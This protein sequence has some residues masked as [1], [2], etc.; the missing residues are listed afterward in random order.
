MANKCTSLVSENVCSL[1]PT[2]NVA[3]PQACDNKDITIMTSN[4]LPHTAATSL[5]HCKSFIAAARLLWGKPS[6]EYLN[7]NTI[8]TT[9][10]IAD[11]GATSI[12][13]MDGVNVVNKCST[14]KPL[15]I[16]M[17]N[18]QQMQSTHIC[19]TAIPGLPT[20]LMGHIVPHLAVALLIGMRPLCNARC[21]VA[22]G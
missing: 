19:D 4:H 8:A 6:H 15:V 14:K 13:I 20:I 10:V 5:F 9:Q 1:D 7:P 11:T 3:V 16:N 21:T 22:F 12:F 2:N 18:G 17:P